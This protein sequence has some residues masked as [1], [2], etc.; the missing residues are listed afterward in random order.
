[1]PIG[2]EDRRRD[3]AEVLVELLAVDRVAVL[4][5]GDE[6]VH[7][8]P[9]IGDR[10]LGEASKAPLGVATDT[11]LVEQGEYDLAHGQSVGAAADLGPQARHP[12]DALAAV[13]GD[14]LDL[15]RMDDPEIRA[16]AREQEELL[17]SPGQARVDGRRGD[18]LLPAG[19][20]LLQ[21]GGGPVDALA[22]V[23][24]K[25]LVA[26]AGEQ[27]IGRGDTLADHLRDLIGA[28]SARSLH[29]HRE[30]AQ[31]RPGRRQ[32]PAGRSHGRARERTNGLALHRDLSFS[33]PRV[34]SEVRRLRPTRS[35]VVDGLSARRYT[36]VTDD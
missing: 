3:T 35:T 28:H 23:H 29:E 32:A 26:E 6:L 8:L 17:N 22:L 18:R 10:V 36:G 33:V 16:P 12:G 15:A 31:D 13:E 4:A 20:E 11:A 19:T 14:D 34:R 2:I 21:P 30:H 9:D 7:Q 1:M 25:A 5:C 24:G 27:V